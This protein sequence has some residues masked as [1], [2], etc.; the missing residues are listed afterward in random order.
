MIEVDVR[1]IAVQAATFLAA[2]G[3]L[4]WLAYKPLMALLDER[5]RQ[6]AADL[7]AAAEA[8]R[9]AARQ[10]EAAERERAEDRRRSEDLFR[11]AVEEGR[12][13]RDS[14][15]REAQDQSRALLA[16]TER[17]LAEERDRAVRALRRE[18]TDLAVRLAEKVMAES[19]T[20][21]AHDRLVDETVEAVE[22]PAPKG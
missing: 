8:R 22:F 6:A 1:V 21:A 12:R 17:R 15:L 11:Q 7:D 18:T 4:R 20:S 13:V 19:L 14:I 16:E 5:T 10:A 2:L 3:L 9:E